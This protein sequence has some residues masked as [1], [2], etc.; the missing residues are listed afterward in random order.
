MNGFVYKVFSQ[1]S[2]IMVA[3]VSVSAGS[4]GPVIDYFALRGDSSVSLHAKIKLLSE[5]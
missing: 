2:A 3:Y 5:K 4:I 1:Q